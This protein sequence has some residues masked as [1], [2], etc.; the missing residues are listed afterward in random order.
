VDLCFGIEIRES[1]GAIVRENDS[2]RNSRTCLADRSARRDDIM[3]V[4][5]DVD[6]A[7]GAE[8]L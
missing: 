8:F 1:R 3:M 7:E 4:A 6:I 2:D 5:P